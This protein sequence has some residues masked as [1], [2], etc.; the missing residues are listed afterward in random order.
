[1]E[2]HNPIVA[3]CIMQFENIVVKPNPFNDLIKII[4]LNENQQ[5]SFRIT[6]SFGQTIIN[7]R[8]LSN[9]NAFIDLSILNSGLYLLI[10]FDSQGN[11]HQY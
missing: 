1:M 5:Y 9:Q 4:G 3:N 2:N 6:N 11:S 8:K 7:D 10:L